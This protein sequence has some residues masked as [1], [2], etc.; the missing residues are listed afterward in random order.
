MAEKQRQE[1]EAAAA[2]DLEQ[3]VAA[4]ERAVEQAATTTS[5]ASASVGAAVATIESEVLPTDSGDGR[6]AMLTSL[7]IALVLASGLFAGLVI[8]HIGARVVPDRISTDLLPRP[9]HRRPGSFAGAS[10]LLMAVALL[11]GFA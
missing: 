10:A 7:L 2:R 4:S 8:L 3:L 5:E 11:V 9:L 6:S 1:R